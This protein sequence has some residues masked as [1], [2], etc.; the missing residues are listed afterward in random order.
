MKC[1]L[2]SIANIESDMI[3]DMGKTID[4][5]TTKDIPVESIIEYFTCVNSNIK[6]NIE[7]T[8]LENIYKKYETAFEKPIEYVGQ[9]GGFGQLEEL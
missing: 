8:G 4:L 2:P 6:L 3:E 5:P 9:C 7:G 1:A